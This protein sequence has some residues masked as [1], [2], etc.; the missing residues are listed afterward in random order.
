D[1]RS[2]PRAAGAERAPCASRAEHGA[3]LD[4]GIRRLSS[5]GALAGIHRLLAAV[6]ADRRAVAAQYRQ[7]AGL[8]LRLADGRG[9]PRHSVGLQLEPVA[10][11]AAGLVWLRQRGAKLARR[12]RGAARDVP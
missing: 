4:D 2:E 3:A 9:H 8:A 11:H 6:D 10:P 1:A 12:Y 5:A 7:P